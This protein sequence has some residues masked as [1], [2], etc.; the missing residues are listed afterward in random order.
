MGMKRDIKEYVNRCSQCQW[1]KVVCQKLAGLFQPLPVSK[2][3]WENVMMDY[4][5][6]FPR[7][8][9]ENNSIWVIVNRLTKTTHFISIRNTHTQTDGQSE[10]CLKVGRS[11]IR[12]EILKIVTKGNWGKIEFKNHLSPA[13]WWTIS[14]SE[15]TIQTL[16]DL[17]WACAIKFQGSWEEHLPLAEFTYN[18][19]YQSS[20]GMAHFEVLYGRK[21]RSLSYWTEVGEAKITRSDIELE[22]KE[23]IRVIQERL[24]VA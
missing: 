1:I 13:D 17:L 6:G 3:N 15:R 22:T 12:I 23:K 8:V 24:K 7:T 10:N 5:V 4:I 9:K 21:C 11:K 20:I 2:W 14:Q 19:S 16:E 18:N